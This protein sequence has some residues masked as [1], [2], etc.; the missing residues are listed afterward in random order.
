MA[1]IQ[2]DP[3]CYDNEELELEVMGKGDDNDEE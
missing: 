1:E 2:A 3:E